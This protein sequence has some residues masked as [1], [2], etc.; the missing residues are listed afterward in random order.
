MTKIVLIGAGSYAFGYT[1]FRDLFHARRELRGS[2]VTLVDIN[3]A[4]LELMTNFAHRLNAIAGNPYTIESTTDRRAALVGAHFVII[5]VAVKR[6][7]LWRLD[8]EIPLRHGAKQVLGENGGPGGLFHAMRNIPILLEIARDIE[9]LAPNAFVINFT[10]P[11]GRLCQALHRYTRL[12]FVGL[13][14]GI[15]M[16]RRVVS[17]TTGVPFEQIDPVAGGLNHFSWVLSLR[18]RDTGEDLYPA[19]RAGI[20]SRIEA[21]E[22]EFGYSLRLS[23]YLMDQFGYWPLPSDDHVGEYISY[24]WEF[25]GLEGYPFDRVDREA[26]EFREQVLRWTNGQD[27][28]ETLIDGGSGERAIPI[29]VGMLHNT[30]Q[31][32]LAVNVPNRGFIPN[33]PDDA[34]VEIPALVDAGGVHGVAIGPLPE[35]IAAMARTQIAVIDRVVEAGVHGDRQAALQALLLDPVISSAQQAEAILDELL[36][37]QRPYLPQF[38]K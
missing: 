28:V 1:T 9:A 27:G 25:C 26:A 23:R 12:K 31:Y 18:H 19:F 2:T 33:L 3:P 37:V 17:L 16:M 35:P 21:V 13:C 5:S 24:A 7:E 6:N 11:E 32:E 30:H 8:F 38:H 20:R 15:D 10:N 14:H 36:E 4:A 34:I 29:I 22:A